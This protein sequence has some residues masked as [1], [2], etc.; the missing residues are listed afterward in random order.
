MKSTNQVRLDVGSKPVL[1]QAKTQLVTPPDLQ[2]INDICEPELREMAANWSVAKRI[3]LAKKMAR[4]VNQLL[5]SAAILQTL[6][7]I[8]NN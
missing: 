1:S 3:R 7:V 6:E 8:K 5:D 2:I 4:W